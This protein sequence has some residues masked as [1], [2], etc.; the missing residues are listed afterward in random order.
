M[1]DLNDKDALAITPSG[2]IYIVGK[3]VD[4]DEATMLVRDAWD[5]EHHDAPSSRIEGGW[6]E[7]VF[8]DY[9]IARQDDKLYRYNYSKDEEGNISFGEREPVEVVYQPIANGKSLAI[10][11]ISEDDTGITVGGYLLL[12]GDEKRVDLQGD[13]F[14]KSTE[15]WMDKYPTVPALF[16]HGLDQDVGMTVMGRRTSHKADDVGVWVEDWL[17]KSSKYWAMVKPLLEA[18]AL[19]YSPGSSQHLI[20]REDD[21]RLK[22]FPVVEDTLTPVP[23]QHRLLP[24]EHIQSAYKS[25]KIEM[26]FQ[27]DTPE[28]EVDTTLKTG[29]PA[30]ADEQRYSGLP[31]GDYNGIPVEP[32]VATVDA[33]ALTILSNI[34]Q[35]EA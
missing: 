35:M 25:A 8:D 4:L 34:R 17:D 3:S 13:Y 16:H 28:A 19:Y 24:I 22:S 14:T 11:T 6:V 21:G 5:K 7:K 1:M 2:E 23:A 31:A 30:G 20:E 15:L 26:T 12:W 9:V 18:E 10:K 29:T 27:L 33:E 32:T